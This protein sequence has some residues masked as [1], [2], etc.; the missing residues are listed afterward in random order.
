MSD[1]LSLLVRGETKYVEF[2]ERYSK[3]ILK[4]VSAFSNYHDGKIIIGITDDGRVIGEN[5]KFR[6][7]ESL[8]ADKLGITEVSEDILKSLELIRNDKYTNAAAIVADSNSF[9]DRG[10]DFICYADQ[11]MLNFMDRINLKSVSVVEEFETAML[12]YKK[13]INQGDMIKGAYRESFDEVPEEAYREAVANAIIHRD[14]SKRG[15]N[16]VEIFE[17]RIEITS[18]GGLPVGI[19][20]EEYVNGNFSNARNRIIADIFLRCRIIEKVGTGVRRIRDAYRTFSQSPEFKIYENSI[21]VILP[22][23]KMA[24]E[25]METNVKQLSLTLEEEKLFNYIKSTNGISRAAVETYMSVGKT[26]ATQLINDLI[27]KG[28]IIKVG[29]GKNTLYKSKK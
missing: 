11:S 12:F 5:L 18:I 25:A 14:Y 22:R 9:M 20:K 23:L 27:D 1:I 10:M 8:L 6:K 16:R 24:I 15:H 13:H 19:S 28:V 4:T 26:K 17:D 3:T 21:Q 2:K 7:L 29:V